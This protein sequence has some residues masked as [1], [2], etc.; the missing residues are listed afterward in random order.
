MKLNEMRAPDG[1]LLHKGLESVLASVE[2]DESAVTELY[3]SLWDV[4][5]AA[6]RVVTAIE[7]L[8]SKDSERDFEAITRLLFKIQSELYSH[9]AGHLNSL[10]PV[11][12]KT[13]TRAADELDAR[14]VP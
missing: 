4:H 8:A 3:T 1:R 14:Q 11:L 6:S 13:A 5:D 12:E 2:R 7:E 9:I 10:A